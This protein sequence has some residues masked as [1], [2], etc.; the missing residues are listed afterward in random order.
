MGFSRQEYWGGVPLDNLSLLPKE[1][2]IVLEAL[3]YGALSLPGKEIK[4][5]FSFSITLPPCFCLALV[6]REPRFWQQG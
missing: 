1:G 5:L 4:P 3:A 6:H 2:A